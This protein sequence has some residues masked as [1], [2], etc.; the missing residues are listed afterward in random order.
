MLA[1]DATIKFGEEL[2]ALGWREIGVCCYEK[3]DWL[4]DL[5]TSSWMDLWTKAKGKPVFTVHVPEVYEARWTAH[6]IEH[7]FSIE[8]ERRR[9]RAAL[10]EIRDNPLVARQTATLALDQCYHKW[11]VNLAIPESQMGRVYCDVCGAMRAE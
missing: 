9:L 8:E 1:T 11:L 5:D 4:F 6:L 3:G 2:K 7:L 10:E